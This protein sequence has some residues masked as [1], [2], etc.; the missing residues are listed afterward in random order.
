MSESVVVKGEDVILPVQLGGRQGTRMDG[1]LAT[2]WDLDFSK[3]VPVEKLSIEVR[4]EVFERPYRL[5]MPA[6]NETEPLDRFTSPFVTLQQGRWN[7]RPDQQRQPLE[8]RLPQET[9][10][11]QMRLVIGDANNPPLNITSV[12]YQAPARQVV[13]ARS[14]EITWPVKVYFGNPKAQNPAYDFEKTVSP[15]V[16]PP[17]IRLEIAAGEP[18]RNPTY[19]APPVPWSEQHPWLVY[20][21]LGIA[22]A[23][24][25]CIMGVLGKQALT[26]TNAPLAA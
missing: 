9:F 14:G 4:D 23:V 7:R 6:G 22:S 13:F 16:E 10:A 12:K 26:R 20:V 8:I 17:P 19:Q 5:E 25:L 15:N 21:V 1:Q 24:L 3:R 2:T 11:R 18:A